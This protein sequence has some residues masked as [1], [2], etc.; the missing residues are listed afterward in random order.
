MDERVLCVDD[1]P[2]ILE[3]FQRLL[4]NKFQIIT[5]NGAEPGLQALEQ[6]GPIAVVLSDQKM[7]GMDGV[8]FL[9][10][11]REIS[12]DSV[13]MMLTGYGALSIAMEAVNEGHVFR[14]LLKPCPYEKLVRALNAAIEQYRLVVA[15]RELL[16]KTLTSS[17]EVLMEAL[18]LSNP[19]A[20]SRANRLKEYSRKIAHRLKLKETWRYEIAAMLSQIGFI[21]IPAETLEKH[22]TG[23]PLG[24]GESRMIENHPNIGETL[25][26]KIPR[27]EAVAEIIK[28]QRLEMAEWD[29][30]SH[31]EEVEPEKIGAQIL[32]VLIHY[33]LLLQRG[34]PAVQAV[35]VL[36][37]QTGKYV[38]QIVAALSEEIPA[39]DPPISATKDEVV[40]S[41]QLEEGMI[42]SEDILTLDG[43]LLVKKGHEINLMLHQ[44]LYN[45]AR[46]GKVADR[47]RVR[48]PNG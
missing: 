22:L 16:E 18:S 11:T 20:F 47:F 8:E 25:I 44:R 14:F 29:P 39:I 9:A 19:L 38:P 40:A 46:Q 27:L 37:E 31:M 2:K 30:G 26:R 12:P 24:E 15:Q 36:V 33:D 43:V 41:G 28:N 1:D 32:R 48:L 13:R 6:K 35:Q 7:P 10:K 4:R 5:A 23:K 3:A 42:L 45:Y 17:I 34:T 21:S